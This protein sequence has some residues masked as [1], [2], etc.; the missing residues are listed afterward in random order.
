M[1]P[2]KRTTVATLLATGTSQREIARLTGV[3]RK[4]IR[5]LALDPTGPEPNPPSLATGSAAANSSTPATG[6][7]VEIGYV[8]VK[9]GKAPTAA[10][11]IMSGELILFAS[12]AQRQPR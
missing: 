9:C 7:G 6:S 10:L 1:K 5:R 8:T 2:N 4:T 3:D 11:N 12:T